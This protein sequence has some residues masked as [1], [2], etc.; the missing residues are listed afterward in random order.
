MESVFSALPQLSYFPGLKNT[1]IAKTDMGK[2]DTSPWFT[3]NTIRVPE[4]LIYI[5]TAV[6]QPAA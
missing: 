6:V 4:L 2:N 3:P 5:S 1:T